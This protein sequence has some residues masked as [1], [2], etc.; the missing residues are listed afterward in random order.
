[1][2]HINDGATGMGIGALVMSKDTF[3]GLPADAKA[4]LERTGKNTG[5]LLTQRIRGIDDGAYQRF[6]A[7]KTVVTLT[8]TEKAAWDGV[9][10]KVRNSL[11]AEGKIRA[12]IFDQV[13]AAA[14]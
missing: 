7:N 9:F 11:K 5:K 1:M 14:Q 4:V 2:D 6:K 3:D 13:V 10:A 12:D 8:P